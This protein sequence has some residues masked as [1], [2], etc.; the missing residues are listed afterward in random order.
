MKKEHLSTA[1]ILTYHLRDVKANL[2]TNRKSPARAIIV[3]TLTN[4][5]T[6]GTDLKVLTKELDSL[7]DT[8]TTTYPTTKLI[9]S[10][11]AP[12]HTHHDELNYLNG[13]MNVNYKGLANVSYCKH[14]KINHKDW[15]EDGIHMVES[16]TSK[17]A[18]K[19]KHATLKALGLKV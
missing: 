2:P 15:W 10:N 1:K 4:D 14:D 6:K 12:R 5:I 9:L 16:G 19:L 3:H 11:I 7:V 13:H 18:G 8:I 17:I